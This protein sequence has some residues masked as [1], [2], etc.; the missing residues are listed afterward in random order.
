[1]NFVTLWPACEWMHL[2]EQIKQREVKETTVYR[3]NVKLTTAV[4]SG[5]YK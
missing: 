1:M 4:T 2:L 5:E 3:V